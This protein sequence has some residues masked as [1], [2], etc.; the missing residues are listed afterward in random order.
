MSCEI[1]LKN[2]SK[3]NGTTTDL[4]KEVRMI[5]PQKSFFNPNHDY[6]VTETGYLAEKAGP[7]APDRMYLILGSRMDGGAF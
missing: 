2:E 7:S 1:C 6:C 4:I 5:G 3:S